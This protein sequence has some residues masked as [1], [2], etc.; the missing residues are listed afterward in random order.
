MR[1]RYEGETRSPIP[2]GA[3]ETEGANKIL[4][5]CECII[6]RYLDRER[7]VEICCVTL[8]EQESH[9]AGEAKKASMSN[10]HLNREI[11]SAEKASANQDINRDHVHLCMWD[12]TSNCVC[13]SVLRLGILLGTVPSVKGSLAQKMI[14]TPVSGPGGVPKGSP[15]PPPAGLNTGI[16]PPVGFNTGIITGMSV[17]TT[18]SKIEDLLGDVYSDVFKQA[19]AEHIQGAALLYTQLEEEVNHM[20]V[21]CTYSGELQIEAQKSASGS[22]DKLSETHFNNTMKL[23]DTR[24][25]QVRAER[26]AHMRRLDGIETSY[27][28]SLR[29]ER[30]KFKYEMAGDRDNAANLTAKALHAGT[31]EQRKVKLQV[32]RVMAICQKMS[33]AKSLDVIA[34]GFCQQGEA[35]IG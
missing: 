8:H 17:L 20:A 3:S 13:Q 16:T 32:G 7:E 26:E 31:E 9:S 15:A 29:D 2:Q 19:T 25:A 24:D 18:M 35:I 14:P 22:R 4:Q 27:K 1:D 23:M 5:T 33:E 30:L 6:E 28:Q 12:Q 21:A 34:V 10:N 11:V